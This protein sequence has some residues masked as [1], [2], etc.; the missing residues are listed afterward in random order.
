MRVDGSLPSVRP[1]YRLRLPV[2]EIAGLH[3]AEQFVGEW[4]DS[5]VIKP[6]PICVRREWAVLRKGKRFSDF[7][8]NLL[9]DSGATGLVEQSGLGHSLFKQRNRVVALPK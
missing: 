6:F 5:A 8:I 9:N 1:R 3:V 2:I 7:L 4:A